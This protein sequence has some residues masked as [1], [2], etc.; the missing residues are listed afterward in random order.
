MQ[1]KLSLV[2][3]VFFCATL[4]QAA[5][6]KGDAVKGKTAFDQCSFCHSIDGSDSGPGPTLQGVFK[7]KTMKNGK[8]MNDA[9]VLDQ[10][11]NGGGGMP[12]FPS[13]SAEDKANLL[14]YLHTL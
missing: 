13:L 6:T 14:A 5:D 11:S 8:P 2:T 7:R 1:R 10:I 12:P 3:A 9:N 4:A